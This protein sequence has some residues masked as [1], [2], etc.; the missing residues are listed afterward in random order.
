MASL[1]KVI[2]T[3]TAIMQLYQEEKIHLKDKVAHY[4][5]N[6][7]ENGKGDVT[8]RQLLTHSSGLKPDIS[9]KWLSN[10]KNAINRIFS[11][12]LTYKPDSKVVYSDLN[13]IVLI[14]IV[15]KVTGKKF[16]DYC[17]Q[18]FF[19]PLGMTHTRF[20]PIHIADTTHIMVYKG[21]N[22]PLIAL[23]SR[24]TSHIAPTAS[25]SNIPATERS[26]ADTTG[27][28]LFWGG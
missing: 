18:Y 17:Q 28:D 11:Q 27:G 13:F 4:L 15:E 19:K 26:E 10:R 2:A 21:A 23:K 3:T 5:P 16:A 14:M 9:L 12:K 25:K 20:Y 1:T 8:I 7:A 22:K 6:F 24:D